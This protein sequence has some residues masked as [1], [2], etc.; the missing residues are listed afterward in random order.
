MIGMQLIDQK[1]C[2]ALAHIWISLVKNCKYVDMDRYCVI[3]YSYLLSCLIDSLLLHKIDD[4]ID[5]HL[6]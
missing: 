3:I 2:G 1:P 5:V 6:L 4:M